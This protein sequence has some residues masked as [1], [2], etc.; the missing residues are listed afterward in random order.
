MKKSDL[1]YSIEASD[2]AGHYFTVT[3]TIAQPHPDGQVLRLAAWLPGSYMIRDFA[4]H[5]VEFEACQ[6]QRL[7]G[8]QLLDKQSWKLQPCD[9][10]IQVKYKVYARD[11]SVRTAYLDNLF[12]FYNHSA[13]CLEVVDQQ[14]KACDVTI[15]LPADQPEW[16]L[17]TGMPR[18]S[19]DAFAT[20]TFRAEN[21][22]EL[23]DYPVLMG[24]LSLED[25]IVKGTRH[26]LAVVGKHFADMERICGD[27]AS[28]C[29][30]QLELFADHAPFADYTFLVM[31]TGDGFGGLEHRNSTALV[32]SRKDLIQPHQQ[33]I[34]PGYRTFLSLCSHEYFH[35]WN[36]KRLRPREF[37]PFDLSHE[38]YTEQLWFY[39]GVTSYYDD[40]LLHRTELSSA[41]HY[42]DTLGQTISRALFGRGPQRQTITQSSWLA[43]TTFYQQNENAPNAIASYYSKGAVTALCADLII[44]QHSNH[45]HSLDDVMRAL[46]QGFGKGERGTR[47]EDLLD[48]LREFGGDP[49]GSFLQRA[50]YS[51]EP[52]PVVEL[53]ADFGVAVQQR[54]SARDQPEQ[55]VSLGARFNAGDQGLEIT[56]V[57]E[58][59]SAYQAGLSAGDRLIAIDALQ[60]TASNQTEFW[61]RYQPE[62][63]VQVHA[64]RRDELISCTLTWQ[65]PPA[66]HYV[67]EVEDSSKL[68][69][70]L[71]VSGGEK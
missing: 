17:T 5:I 1:H 2:C 52:M 63:R 23:I 22:A 12:G 6:G 62:E 9:G 24:Q 49:M 19:G 10:P 25:F 67:L 70:W 50:L 46:W 71:S 3:L 35:S 54:T 44:R 55:S 39:E 48:A 51:T 65:A 33:Q 29:E 18:V 20:G 37:I 58:G 15:H 60:V 66:T 16:Q 4:R 69:G 32:C 64:F 30:V 34:T 42:L 43:W 45:E 14:D 40:Y 28:I 68:H 26:R 47:V 38:Q 57:Y 21:Y 8:Y 7:L 27:L 53:L 61:N 31:V 41:R 36:I 56:H 59:G 11:L 13:L